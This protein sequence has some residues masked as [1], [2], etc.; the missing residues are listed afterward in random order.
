MYQTNLKSSKVSIYLLKRSGTMLSLAR[1][2]QTNLSSPITT[3]SN[4]THY[5]FHTRSSFLRNSSN[6]KSLMQTEKSQITASQISNHTSKHEFC[7]HSKSLNK[8]HAISHNENISKKVVLKS[9][10]SNLT[11]ESFL[12]TR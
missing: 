12:T 8:K 1:S 2:F 7:S 10:L 5:C 6:V 9:S 11:I 3:K 4:F